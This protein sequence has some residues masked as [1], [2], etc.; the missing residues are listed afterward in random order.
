MNNEEF[1][2]AVSLAG[3]Q[4]RDV[5]GYEGLYMVSNQ[6]RVIS[7]IREIFQGHGTY[8]RAPKL[9]RPG[10][11]KARKLRYHT[12]QLYDGL[13]CKRMLIHRIEM[14]D[15]VPNPDNY[16][17]VD[18]I[19]RDC[20]D[21]RLENLRWCSRKMNMA[22]EKTREV[23]AVCHKGADKSYLWKPVARVKDGVILQTY[24]S[25]TEATKEG[26]DG[27]NIVQ[28][29]RGRK[30]THRGYQWVYLDQINLS[31][32]GASSLEQLS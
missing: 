16:S 26:Y 25:I 18:H 31:D 10:I 9:L 6:G 14:I 3:E 15:F 4:W 24:R 21:N 19:N 8:A 22:N 11:I 2:K 23:L 5:V 17:D 7:L 28:V 13:S 12:V 27:R 1:I 29:C 30:K 32:Y 20:L